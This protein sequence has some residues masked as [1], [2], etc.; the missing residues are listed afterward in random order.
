[1]WTV[2]V[3]LFWGRGKNADELRRAYL[4]L[5]ILLACSMGIPALLF[6]SQDSVI[7]LGWGF[8]HLANLDF[9]AR[10]LF[11]DFPVEQSLAVGVA[12]AFMAAICIVVGYLF[13][14][15]VLLIERVMKRRNLFREAED[16]DRMPP[17]P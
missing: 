2:I 4:F 16:A 14:G 17:V 11:K 12:W 1:T 8:L 7:L 6:Y 10:A 15:I 5:P 3:M 13:I 9:M